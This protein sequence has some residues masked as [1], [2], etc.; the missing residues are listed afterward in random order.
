[1]TAATRPR[2]PA[3]RPATALFTRDGGGA[4]PH[5]YSDAGAVTSSIM[6]H[7]RLAT[8]NLLSRVGLNSKDFM[9]EPPSGMMHPDTTPSQSLL[10]SHLMPEMLAYKLMQ[11][12]AQE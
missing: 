10:A 12:L 9:V 8:S 6:S 7:S 3:P 11:C 5:P 2:P 1:M 4:S